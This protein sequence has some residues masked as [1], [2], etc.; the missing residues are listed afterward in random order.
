MNTFLV[1]ILCVSFVTSGLILLYR[2]FS[3]FFLKRYGAGLKQLI[4]IIFALRLVIPVSFAEIVELNFDYMTVPKE[5]VEK[6]LP[7]TYNNSINELF[8][9]KLET[10]VSNKEYAMPIMGIA[11]ETIGDAKPESAYDLARHIS[12]IIDKIQYEFCL[13]I[14]LIGRIYLVGVIAFLLIHWLLYVITCWRV[15]R[16]AY[17]LPTEKYGRIIREIAGE[18]ALYIIPDVYVTDCIS[19]PMIMSVTDATIYLPKPDYT[20]DELEAILRHELMHL[21]HKDL[22]IKRLYLLANAMHWFNPLCYYIASVAGKDM[23]LYCDQDVVKFYD[24]DRRKQYNTILLGFLEDIGGYTA[25]HRFFTTSYQGDVKEM[26]KRFYNNLDM[27]KK[28]AG[29]FPV[30]I[31]VIL[32][33]GLSAVLSFGA[34]KVMAERL[35]VIKGIHKSGYEDAFNYYDK[36]ITENEEYAFKRIVNGQT[37]LAE[38]IYEGKTNIHDLKPARLED[39]SY[40]IKII[41]ESGEDYLYAQKF[42][43]PPDGEDF[44]TAPEIEVYCDYQRIENYG[45]VFDDKIEDY[46]LHGEK[47]DF[48]EKQ[49]N[50]YN[51]VFDVYSWNRNISERVDVLFPDGMTPDVVQVKDYVL[52]WK[53]DSCYEGE[54]HEMMYHNPTVEKDVQFNIKGHLAYESYE[55]KIRQEG[56]LPYYRGIEMDCYWVTESGYHNATYMFV[57]GTRNPHY[58]GE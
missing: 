38:Q 45:V 49:Y 58:D 44:Q 31:V 6:V 28:K 37:L 4:W 9:G 24:I 41:A 50:E 30:T 53:G 46:Y 34:Q 22:L 21:S 1:N 35:D 56:A 2:L 25:K 27:K 42:I 11:S 51:I 18:Y 29:V 36:Y 13:H 26:K 43:V 48:F 39:G 23:E 55:G 12:L 14:D 40:V 5:T 57:I 52:D 8:Y 15:N 19:S 54:Y 3:K 20:D 33:L 17:K 32:A 16:N 7:D 47:V 10:V